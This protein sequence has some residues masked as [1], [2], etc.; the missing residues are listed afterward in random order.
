MQDMNGQHMNCSEH[1]RSRAC[2]AKQQQTGDRRGMAGCASAMHKPPYL[3]GADEQGD[4]PGQGVL[5]HG[6]DA[7]LWMNDETI[8]I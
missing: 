3:D 4:E 8:K 5:V 2:V 7:G 1:E 6:V